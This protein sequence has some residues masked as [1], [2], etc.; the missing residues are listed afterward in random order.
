[1]GH[2]WGDVPALLL[3]AIVLSALVLSSQLANRAI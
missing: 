3:V 1:M 2:L